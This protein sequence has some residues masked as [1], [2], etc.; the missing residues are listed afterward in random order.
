L[1][2]DITGINGYRHYDKQN[3]KDHIFRHADI[4]L[5]NLAIFIRCGSICRNII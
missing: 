4:P 1:N 5:K 2:Q 3:S